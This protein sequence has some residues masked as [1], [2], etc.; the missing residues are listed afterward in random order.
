MSRPTK[1]RLKNAYPTR[2]SEVKFDDSARTPFIAPC[3]VNYFLNVSFMWKVM[4]V[5]LCAGGVGLN[6]I[7]GN[8]LFLMD[9]HW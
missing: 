8:H 6:L 2:H 5:S 3:G 1:K 9:M 4:L 7:G